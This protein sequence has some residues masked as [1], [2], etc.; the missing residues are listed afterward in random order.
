MKTE[1]RFQSK[2]DKSTDIYSDVNNVSSEDAPRE[3]DNSNCQF[4]GC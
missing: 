4:P 2:Q 1:V 3:H